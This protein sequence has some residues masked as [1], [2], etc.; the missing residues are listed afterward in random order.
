M[1]LIHIIYYKLYI[2][3]KV[4]IS[5]IW[6]YNDREIHLCW[7]LGFISQFLPRKGLIYKM[8]IYCSSVARL[9]FPEIDVDSD[10]WRQ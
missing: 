1:H 4:F 3:F 9:S 7:S 5:N 8:L 6:N 2:V 10:Q